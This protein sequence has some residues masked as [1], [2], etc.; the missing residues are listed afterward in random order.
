MAWL[1]V[2][3]RGHVNTVA[4]GGGG[5]GGLGSGGWGVGRM[6]NRRAVSEGVSER[7]TVGIKRTKERKS[8]TRGTGKW[9]HRRTGR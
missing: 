7:E 6:G 8:L 3:C 4:P 1:H 5:G 9:V 2:T